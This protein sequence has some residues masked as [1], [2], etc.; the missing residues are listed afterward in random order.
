VKEHDWRDGGPAKAQSDCFAQELVE[1][2]IGT[3]AAKIS[4]TEA[5]PVR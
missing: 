1:S 5:Y 3:W 2:A 4:L